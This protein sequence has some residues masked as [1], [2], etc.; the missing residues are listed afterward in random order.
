MRKRRKAECLLGS[1]LHRAVRHAAVE[2]E[3]PGAE[4]AAAEVLEGWS[5]GEERQTVQAGRDE[6]R[7][8]AA[9][10]SRRAF[11]LAN[12]ESIAVAGLPLG[13]AARRRASRPYYAMIA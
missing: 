11:R 6:G 1:Q 8:M 5:C 9:I 10:E 2:G 4:R 12:S 3:A 13:G 7:K